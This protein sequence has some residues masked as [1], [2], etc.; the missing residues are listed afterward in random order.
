MVIEVRGRRYVISEYKV[1]YFDN[2]KAFVYIYNK[3]NI[4]NF[5]GKVVMKRSWVYTGTKIRVKFYL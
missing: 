5:I 4:V 2:F 1:K 3:W